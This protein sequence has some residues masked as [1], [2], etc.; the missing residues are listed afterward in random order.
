[1]KQ[2]DV[3]RRAR[4]FADLLYDDPVEAERSYQRLSRFARKLRARG[5]QA[6]LVSPGP[7]PGCGKGGLL[8]HN[9]VV[10]FFDREARTLVAL[11]VGICGVC[12][13]LIALQLPSSDPVWRR[14]TREARK[15]ALAS[16]RPSGEAAA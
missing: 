13:D 16:G 1:M 5:F 4:T 14:V 6:G 12:S 9:A 2:A 8:E 10:A 15:A 3:L 11:A 7:C